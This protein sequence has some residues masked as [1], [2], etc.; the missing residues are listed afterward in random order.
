MK[1]KITQAARFKT[2]NMQP[3][4]ELVSKIRAV[5]T[6]ATN[7]DLVGGELPIATEKFADALINISL[8]GKTRNSGWVA[9]N[10]P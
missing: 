4:E 6:F 2:E 7:C 10:I 5:K 8:E 1:R 3:S 9:Q